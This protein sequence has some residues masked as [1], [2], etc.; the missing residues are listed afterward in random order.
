[1]KTVGKALLA[2]LP[3]TVGLAA[4]RYYWGDWWQAGSTAANLGR[5]ATAGLGALALI[6]ALYYLLRIE[7]VTIV[8]KRRTR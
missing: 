4:M 8:L 2:V 3:A 7:V 6:G 1:M 5:V